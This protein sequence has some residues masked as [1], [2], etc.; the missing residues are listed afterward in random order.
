[1][2]KNTI[3][4]LFLFTLCLLCS[5]AAHAYVDPGTGSLLVQGILGLI[6]GS[7]LFMRRSIR[8]VFGLV[9]GKRIE[10][11]EDFSSDDLDATEGSSESS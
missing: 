7:L 2:P 10:L 3:S 6:L 1:M 9:T 4:R 11:D 5:P 8:R